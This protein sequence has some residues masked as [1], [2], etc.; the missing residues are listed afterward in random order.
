MVID[1]MQDLHKKGELP[2][3]LGEP[4]QY[5]HKMVK[6]GCFGDEPFLYGAAVHLKRDI[7]ILHLHPATI[8]NGLFNWVR[9]EKFGSDHSAQM[10]NI[11]VFR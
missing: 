8:T 9:G 3:V 7:I 11:F 6:P 1:E 5:F 2:D 10:S 4:Y